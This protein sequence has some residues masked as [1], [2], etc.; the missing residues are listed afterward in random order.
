MKRIAFHPGVPES[1]YLR[2]V[3]DR[4]GKRAAVFHRVMADT[5]I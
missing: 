5:V 1:W 2:M 4:R 3:A